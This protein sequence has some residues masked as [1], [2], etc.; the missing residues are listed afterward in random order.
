MYIILSYIWDDKY[1]SLS[2]CIKCYNSLENIKDV[3]NK[4][5]KFVTVFALKL[6]YSCKNVF[7]VS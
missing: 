4:N 7:N 2:S 5:L 1:L 3:F 6:M